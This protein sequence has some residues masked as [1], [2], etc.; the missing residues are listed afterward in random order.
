MAMHNG[1]CSSRF[2]SLDAQGQYD[3]ILVRLQSLLHFWRVCVEHPFVSVVQMSG[4]RARHLIFICREY[5]HTAV[6][7]YA[8]DPSE[9][10]QIATK[11]PFRDPANMLSYTRG[12]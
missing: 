1:S 4:N 2:D 6:K 7:T 3:T 9:A 10:M 12:V 8:G 11:W 5:L